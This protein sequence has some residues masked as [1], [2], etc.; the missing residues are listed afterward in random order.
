MRILFRR[1]DFRITTRR[2]VLF[3]VTSSQVLGLTL[4]KMTFFSSIFRR[5]SGMM[6]L[7]RRGSKVLLK[8]VFLLK[9]AFNHH[10]NDDNFRFLLTLKP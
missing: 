10:I 3:F 8:N 2:K 6:H 9:S 5:T 1:T 7:E 4:N